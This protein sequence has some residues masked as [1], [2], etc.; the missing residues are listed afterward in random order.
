MQ[1]RRSGRRSNATPTNRLST[2]AC[3]A[4]CSARDAFPRRKG[5]RPSR[6]TSSRT[7]SRAVRALALAALVGVIH[8]PH[9]PSHDSDASFAEV[10]AAADQAGLD[11]VVLT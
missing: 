1:S 6:R 3:R 7:S 8:V 4:S 9:E 10:L 2:E 5:L 11:F